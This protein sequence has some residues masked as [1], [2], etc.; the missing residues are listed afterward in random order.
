MPDYE[1]ALAVQVTD[2]SDE[3]A[4]RLFERGYRDLEIEKDD[5]ES[6]GHLFGEGL[7]EI[8]PQLNLYGRHV[9]EKLKALARRAQEESR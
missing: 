9:N 3:L 4:R 7:V 8:T 2:E 5:F 6:A 1:H